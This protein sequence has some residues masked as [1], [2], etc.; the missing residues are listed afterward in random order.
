MKL[1]LVVFLAPLISWSKLSTDPSE[2]VLLKLKSNSDIRSLELIS[3][4]L[5]I[6][7]IEPVFRKVP[8]GHANQK[9]W[10]ALGLDRWYQ[11]KS[12]F[13]SSSQ[14]NLIK[15]F[16]KKNFVEFVEKDSY[17]EPTSLPNDPD[18]SKQWSLSRAKL[19]H[20]DG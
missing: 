17:V 8:R 6:D 11:V 19:D 7:S 16:K 12:H 15:S 20:P 5:N 10:E 2:Y 14:D 3:Q 18:F 13:L 1:F 9:A 4:D